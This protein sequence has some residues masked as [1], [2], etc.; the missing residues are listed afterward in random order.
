M[1]A[2]IWNTGEVGTRRQNLQTVADA[3]AHAAVS[4]VA[5]AENIESAAKKAHADEFIQNLPLKYATQLEE[6]GKNLSGGQQQRL[7]IARA[8]VKQAPILVMDEATSSL[9]A[10]SENKIHSAVAALHGQVTQVIIAHRLG[11]I[12]HADRIIYIDRGEKIAEGTK[13]ELLQ[14]CDPFRLMW[15]TLYRTEK[16]P[17]VAPTK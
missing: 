8:L 7:A 5:R 11:T 15:E 6:G 4:W 1:V 14:S 13:A 16:E 3:T 2:L 9:D 17:A 12:E 10:I